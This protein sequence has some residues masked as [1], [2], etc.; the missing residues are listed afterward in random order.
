VKSCL[1]LNKNSP[2]ILLFIR[3]S[4]SI[5]PTITSFFS[6]TKTTRK[7]KRQENEGFPFFTSPLFSPFTASPRVSKKAK[8]EVLKVEEKVVE[9]VHNN[10]ENHDKN[11]KN[12]PTTQETKTEEE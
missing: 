11:M 5:Q 12:Q 6:P 9:E 7:R 8:G 3:I 2:A 1:F 10:K 4:M